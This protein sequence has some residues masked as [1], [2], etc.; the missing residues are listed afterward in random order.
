MRCFFPWPF[1]ELVAVK[2]FTLRVVRPGVGKAAWSLLLFPCLEGSS[3]GWVLPQPFPRLAVCWGL[4]ALQCDCFIPSVLAFEL[5][6]KIKPAFLPDRA[7]V[8]WNTGQTMDPFSCPQYLRC[9]SL[10]LSHLKAPPVCQLCYSWIEASLLRCSLQSLG[11]LR[12]QGE[13]LALN[14]LVTLLTPNSPSFFQGPG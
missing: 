1:W 13:G 8:L 11:Q 2:V 12:A 4:A 7:W 5:H 9:I 6:S 3:S 14:S 10:P